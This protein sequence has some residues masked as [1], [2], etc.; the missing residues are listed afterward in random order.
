ME[1]PVLKEAKSFGFPYQLGEE[2][3]W[4]IFPKQRGAT[5]KLTSASDSQWILSLKNIPQLHLASEEAIAFLT[6]R[7]RSR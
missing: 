2:N 1:Q 7:A 3:C 4:Q 5:W 6:R